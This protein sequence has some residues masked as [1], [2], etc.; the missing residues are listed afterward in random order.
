MSV[1]AELDATVAQMAQMDMLEEEDELPSSPANGATTG[2]SAPGGFKMPDGKIVPPD[3]FKI[4]AILGVGTF[5]RVRMI[6]YNGT[7]YA[8]KMMKK[9]K[10]D[11]LKQKQHIMNEKH[12]MM[13]MRHP[14]LLQLVSTYKD[15]TFLYMLLE[16]CQGG[17]LFSRLLELKTLDE[18]TTR[19]YAGG[20]V[21]ALEALHG[22]HNIYRDL[23]PENILLDTQ[24]YVK[25]VDF[26]FAKKVED[27]THTTCGTPEYVSPEML[28]HDG[29]GKATD[30]WTLGIFIYECLC[31]T[32][33]FAANN[34]LSTYDKILAY[35]K[36][37]RLRW[38]APVSS[39]VQS[40]ISGL[41]A[42][43]PEQRLGCLPGGCE[44]I[45]GH[46]WF[47]GFDW[48]L[49]YDKKIVAPWVPAVKSA[50]DTSFFDPEDASDE[51]DTEEY[52]ADGSW[53]DNF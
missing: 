53:F 12:I 14:F 9:L 41:M 37:G 8:M 20:I 18:D 44:D 26:G 32:T 35:A 24:G 27:R 16:I 46:P 29:H 15:P 51:S 17:E 39:E 36:H 50:T 45:K 31:G 11:Q 49:L 34:Y 52:M 13:E 48:Q 43:V 22:K 3:K 21:L 5:S 33:P 40:L 42:P 23:K 1:K 25:V 30:Y 2:G 7:V 10:I 28:E 6:E 38:P 47:L 4:I 19:F